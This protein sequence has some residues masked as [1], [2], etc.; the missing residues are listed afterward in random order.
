M[1]TSSWAGTNG[2]RLMPADP[3]AEG[4]ATAVVTTA[5]G[6]NLTSLAYTWVHPTDGPQDGL[7]VWGP[8]VMAFWGD[9][10]HQQ[11][12]PRVLEGSPTYDGG[13]IELECE[14]GGG[15]RWQIGVRLD[16][17]SVRLEMRNVIPADQ[18]DAG[19][20]AGPYPVM[21]MELRPAG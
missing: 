18:V 20:Q 5:A 21:V 14:Y 7:L 19:E 13:G 2:F 11:P 12:E 9:S 16:A 6:G 3:L 17:D 1:S 10:W 15:W 4:P 8:D